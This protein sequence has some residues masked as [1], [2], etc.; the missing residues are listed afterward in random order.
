M[1]ILLFFSILLYIVFRSF[2]EKWL[3]NFPFNDQ[4]LIKSMKHYPFHFCIHNPA[5]YQSYFGPAIRFSFNSMAKRRK[6]IPNT[7]GIQFFCFSFLVF[8]TIQFSYRCGSQASNQFLIS[9]ILF[10]SRYNV[11]HEIFKFLA[12]SY[13]GMG[14]FE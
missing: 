9:V 12:F 6:T 2:S 14:Y 11:E 4:S 10:D 1:N 13:F 8:F 5:L 3:V 7:L